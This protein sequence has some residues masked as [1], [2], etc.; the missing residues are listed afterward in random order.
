MFIACT[1]SQTPRTSR[2]NHLYCK[3]LRGNPLSKSNKPHVAPR[4]RKQIEPPIKTRYTRT[5]TCSLPDLTS[6]HSAN[7]G[8][9]E[10]FESLPGKSAEQFRAKPQSVKNTLHNSR[11][12]ERALLSLWLKKLKGCG[13]FSSPS[14]DS[15]VWVRLIGVSRR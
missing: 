9:I 1:I 5:G 3:R 15:V 2:R 10:L 7:A 6:Q 8:L 14:L 12:F 11:F 4:R 13:R